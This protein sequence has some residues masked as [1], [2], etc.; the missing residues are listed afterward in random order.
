MPTRTRDYA[1]MGRI[2][3]PTSWA[4]TVD[5]TAR[6]A[7][8]RAKS[9]TSL[10]YHLDNLPAQ[11]KDATEAQRLAAAEAARTAYFRQLAFRSAKARR[12]RGAEIDGPFTADEIAA[13]MRAVAAEDAAP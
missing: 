7:P 11:F 1:A 12:A 13:A 4:N 9:P 2:G 10:Q 6:T 5:R 3:G 8:A